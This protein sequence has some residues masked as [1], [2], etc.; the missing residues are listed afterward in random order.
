[1]P[2]KKHFSCGHTGLGKYCHAC[3]AIS[4]SPEPESPVSS[5]ASDV[6]VSADQRFT[7]SI[8]CIQPNQL[9]QKAHNILR[10]ILDEGEPYTVFGGKRMQ[11]SRS[12]ISIPVGYR[13]R[14]VLTETDSGDKQPLEAMSH[15]TYNRYLKKLR[16]NT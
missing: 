15:E 11:F 12:I 8:A 16:S 10:R 5:V 6:F 4:K 3:A 9:R 1:M 13:F 7:L 2:R 14:L